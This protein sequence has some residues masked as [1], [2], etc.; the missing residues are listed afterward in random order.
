MVYRVDSAV[1]SSIPATLNQLERPDVGGASNNGMKCHMHAS[2]CAMNMTSAIRRKSRN[3]PVCTVQ[4]PSKAANV[5][6]I[7]SNRASFRR[8]T[9]RNTRNRRNVRKNKALSSKKASPIR[10]KGTVLNTSMGP[11]V[12]Q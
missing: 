12:R 9:I 7:L 4:M 5:F 8:R 11:H 1:E 2:K 3:T 6:L 10:S